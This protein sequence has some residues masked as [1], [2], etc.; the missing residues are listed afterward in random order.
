MA[1][2][3]NLEEGRERARGPSLAP[4]MAL[5]GE[6]LKRVNEVI[7]RRMH[8]PVALIPQ[9]AGHIVAAGGKRMRPMLTLAAARLCGVASGDRHVSLAAC[10]EFI[11]T[12]TLL[13]DDVVDESDLRRGRA[14][15][16][17]VWGNKSSVL[18]GDFLF[19]RAFQVM[20]EDGSLDVLRILSNASAVIA[21]GEVLQ[22][23]TANDT[24]TTENA[25]L[26]VIRAKT[27][28]LFAAAARVGA[29]VAG[30]P[31]AEEDALESY[32][33][34]L[35]IAFQLVDDVIDYASTAEKMGKSVGDDFRDGKITLPV[36]LAFLRGDDEERQFWRRTLEALDQRPGDLEHAIELMNRHGSL[37]DTVERARH[38]GAI[39]RDALG[40]FPEHP[41][42]RALAELVEFAIHRAH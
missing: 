11:H 15:A 22:L 25:Y 27:A 9:L 30:R 36:V 18:V 13:H 3:V 20:V 32:G 23:T 35:G 40:I 42:K 6:D 39:A 2:V 33:L 24:E 41:V 14:T 31:R 29:I 17:A 5:V 34:N 4:L 12:A 10:V 7:V 8:S 37:R 16:N 28:T 21:E 26:E 19:S 38:Y 1:I